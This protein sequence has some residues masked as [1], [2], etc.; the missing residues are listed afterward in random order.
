MERGLK[1]TGKVVDFSCCISLHVQLNAAFAR[2][3][4]QHCDHVK[5]LLTPELLCAGF[6]GT[7]PPYD[8]V[9]ATNKAGLGDG[10]VQK[11]SFVLSAAVDV[12]KELL[13]NSKW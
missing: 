11:A 13:E 7:F 6:G 9:I 3:L 4:R 8:L 1:V 10:I 12:G 5:Y 2:M